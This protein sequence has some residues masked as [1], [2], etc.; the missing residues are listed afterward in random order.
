MGFIILFIIVIIIILHALNLR[1]E[2]AAPITPALFANNVEIINPPE[3]IVLENNSLSCHE[4]LTPC[5]TDADCQLCREGTAKC[6]EFLEPVQ[7]DDAHTIQRGEKYCLA[8]SNKGSRTCN[9]YTGNWMLRRVEEGVYSLLCN[10]L[11][12]G[13]VTQLTIY[14]DCD[15]PVGCKPNGSIIN[16][17]TTPLTCECDDGYVS[18]I[19]DTGTPYCRPKVLRDVVLDPN[20]F[21]RPPCPAGFVPADHPALFRFYRNQIGANV[22]VPDPCSI[23]PISGERHNAGRLLYSENGGQD[24]GPLAMCVC[25]IEQNVYPV[26]SPESMIDTAYSNCATDVNCDSEITNACLK[27]LIVDR[28]EVRSDLKVFWG[29]N[30]LKSDAE[31]V[32]QLNFLQAHSKYTLIL[33]R[34][35]AP[36]PQEPNS[37]TLSV[38]KFM[39][40]TAYTRDSV[41]SPQKDIFQWYWNYNYRRTHNSNNCP[42]PGIGECRNPQQCGNISCTTNPCIMSI[43]SNSYRNQCYFFKAN[44]TFQD[45][46]EVQQICVW[47]SASFY[48]KNN[49][50]VIFYINARMALESGYGVTNDY[51]RIYFVNSESTVPENQYDTLASILDTFPL[52]RS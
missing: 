35:T 40:T 17:H 44:R 45:V 20:F 46:G 18:E 36:H 49:V 6:Q 4:V 5:S 23:D 27:P 14:D 29:R 33:A 22:C 21:P 31:I 2:Y 43:V 26:Y 8:L 32:F 28:K 30:S 41:F 9:P 47:N 50:P 42:L 52:Y 24:G 39:L 38:L 48:E 19:S 16:L 13:I 11:V 12:P 10:C 7:I 15:F 3:S 34:R 37:R 1:A 51:Q 25:D